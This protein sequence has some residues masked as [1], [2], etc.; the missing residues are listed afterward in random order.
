MPRASRFARP[1]GFRTGW[2]IVDWTDLVAPI[3]LQGIDSV[4]PLNGI[5]DRYRMNGPSVHAGELRS[6]S[7]TF[8]SLPSPHL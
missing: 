1:T 5:S 3:V 7:R 6:R 4:R 8:H 2:I